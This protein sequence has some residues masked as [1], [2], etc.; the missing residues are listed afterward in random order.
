MK[1]LSILGIVI[2][3]ILLVFFSYGFYYRYINDNSVSRF[4]IF[5]CIIPSILGL[6]SSV[7]VRTQGALLKRDLYISIITLIILLIVSFY[8]FIHLSTDY[9]LNYVYFICLIL[10]I[11]NTIFLLKRYKSELNVIKTTKE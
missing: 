2:S 1:V 8:V 6:I 11:T 3:P 7:R 4:F 9:L 10:Y 5:I